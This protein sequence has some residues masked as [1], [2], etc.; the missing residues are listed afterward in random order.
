MSI[1]LAQSGIKPEG[2][3]QPTLG[4]A[5]SGIQPETRSTGGGAVG[6]ADS[7]ANPS[8][9]TGALILDEPLKTI[10]IN[11]KNITVKESVAKALVLA[12]ED[13]KADTGKELDIRDSFRSGE[14]QAQIYG[15]LNGGAGGRVAPPGTSFHQSG[16]AIDVNNWKEAES[17]LK[18]YNLVNDLGDDKGHFSV[19]EF[20]DA[21]PLTSRESTED[22]T[23]RIISG[24]ERGIMDFA[25]TKLGEQKQGLVNFAESLK[26]EDEDTGFR[27]PWND[28]AFVA[29]FTALP[30]AI[31]ALAIGLFKRG[32]AVGDAS[33]DQ[34]LAGKYV[35]KMMR[36]EQLTLEE[37]ANLESA[38]NEM[39]KALGDLIE[40]VPT[41]AT[42]YVGGSAS[43]M[44]TSLQEGKST[45]EALTR[46]QI[47]GAE[48]AL[49]IYIL[50]KAINKMTGADKKKL[51]EEARKNGMS[52]RDI[53]T[54]AN[55]KMSVKEAKEYLETAKKSKTSYRAP[56]TMEIPGKDLQNAQKAL[57]DKTD[58]VGSEIGKIV[59]DIGG[60][61]AKLNLASQADDFANELKRMNIKVKSNG[62]LDFS[63]SDIANLS[64][65][66]KLLTNIWK[67]LS[68]GKM[69]VR[70][71]IAEARNV[72]NQLYSGSVNQQ[73]TASEAVA[74]KYQASLRDAINQYADDVGSPELAQLN[75]AYHELLTFNNALK[76]VIKVEGVRAPEFLRR[77]YSN[78]NSEP[79]K[80]LQELDDLSYKYNIDAGK[81][82]F[83]KGAMAIAADNAAQVPAPP[84][85]LKG[86]VG[87]QDILSPKTSILQRLLGGSKTPNTASSFEKLLDANIKP[88]DVT[89]PFQSSIP[90]LPN[91]L[92]GL[93]KN[94][95]SNIG[96]SPVSIGG[97]SMIGTTPSTI[98]DKLESIGFKNPNVQ[99][100]DSTPDYQS[101]LNLFNS[102][103]PTAYAKP[104]I[105]DQPTP[106]IPAQPSVP[107]QTPTVPLE[108]FAPNLAKKASGVKQMLSDIGKLTPAQ[109]QQSITPPTA[110]KPVFEA[111]GLIPDAFRNVKGRTEQLNQ[112]MNELENPKKPTPALPNKPI[113]EI[114]KE[115]DTAK[116]IQKSGD[117][118][119][120][121]FNFKLF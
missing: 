100:G 102:F 60:S 91:F 27:M 111:K 3:P 81:G 105:P 54:I 49:M 96:S 52:E 16:Q 55:K 44:A 50:N 40:L 64:A 32:Y 104:R 13:F 86:Q 94:I 30:K 77:A 42:Q 93:G 109:I 28:K 106:S 56:R 62:T 101:A 57:L 20:S 48:Q 45:E 116:A 89:S 47:Q 15:D 46:G 66:Q 24:E 112:I 97:Q 11:G 118:F 87:V 51:I 9:V 2:N 119:K 69:G 39:M 14:K 12:N 82:L 84:N 8:P 34:L 114:F 33:V 99:I 120:K 92:Q 17:Y 65:D 115:S 29:G 10:K 70:D 6:L 53:D 110:P 37:Q 90:G 18:K 107:A 80:I 38:N 76:R 88:S 72:G 85:S 95:Y 74:A 73:L 113:G 41:P 83:D 121:A 67:N 21:P 58:D 98:L 61:K 103:I 35:L 4:L 117:I 43:E 36:G 7:G 108:L 68:K 19:G 25:K 5:G 79:M 1:G 23:Q 59:D 75:Q 63:K 71:A 26:N 31:P 22:I 78:V